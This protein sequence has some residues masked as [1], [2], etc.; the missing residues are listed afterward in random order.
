MI[1]IGVD[2]HKDQH[3]AQALDHL[4]QVLGEI[5]IETTSAGY[6]RLNSWA[7]KFDDEVRFGIEGCGTY[8]AGLCRFLQACGQEV[9]EVERPKRQRRR[10]GKSDSLDAL[11]AARCV[12]SG[13]G[14]SVPRQGGL[15]HRIRVLLI[16]HNSCIS[17]RTRLQNQIQALLI[18][19]PEALRERIGQGR[20]KVLEKRIAKM[21]T[22]STMNS[23]QRTTFVV[24]RDLA[25]RSIELLHKAN[26]YD[27][28]ITE[29]I[30]EQNPSLLEE[31]G[32]GPIT[33]AQLIISDAWR[34][35]NEQAFALANGTAPI[36]ASSGKITRYRLNRGGD[37]Q[38]NRAIHIIALARSKHH[39]ETREFL[40]RRMSDGKTKREAMRVLKRH[41]SRRLF[42]QITAVP[43]T[44]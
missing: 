36:P 39:P 25:R 32:I 10:K 17:E 27:R 33:A 20:G 15:R 26:Q 42:R 18:S 16:A 38:V 24:M 44:S 22:A 14:L 6:K 43:L 41:L 40:D 2:T 5:R 8:G 21:R 1:A 34:F 9:F 4:G 19:A 35:K 12:I 11:I 3:T 13:E 7:E 29:L 30:N 23:S 28:Q 37:R 31:P